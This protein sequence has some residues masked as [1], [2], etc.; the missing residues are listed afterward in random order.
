M[1][2]RYVHALVLAM[3]TAWFPPAVATSAPSESQPQSPPRTP[4][5][6]ESQSI[7]CSPP[8]DLD[9]LFSRG[10]TW[11]SKP[12]GMASTGLL[13][14]PFDRSTL[15]RDLVVSNGND[16]APQPI[17]IYYARKGASSSAFPSYATLPEWVSARHARHGHLAAGDIDRDGLIDLVAAVIVGHP[18]KITVDKGDLYP[19]GGL[20]IYK[21]FDG[22]ADGRAGDDACDRRKTLSPEPIASL[23]GFAAMSVS[24]GD[25]N[26]DGWL[27]LAVGALVESKTP[28]ALPH[29][30][31]KGPWKIFL[32]DHGKFDWNDPITSEKDFNATDVEL[33]DVDLDG[34]LDL[35]MASSR[36]LRVFYGKLGRDGQPTISRTAGWVSDETEFELID[37]DLAPFI[38]S[39]DVAVMNPAVDR[40]SVIV[41]SVSCLQ[42]H[43]AC[44]G[45][46]LLYR[47]DAGGQNRKPIWSY[48]WPGWGGEVRL[49][50]MD[51]D[52]LTDL[53]GGSWFTWNA[54]KQETAPAQIK[55]FLG[56]G[57]TLSARPS[58][59]SEVEGGFVGQAIELVDLSCDAAEL[60]TAHFASP[61][62]AVTLTIPDANFESVHRVRVVI[63]GQEKT[64][65][66]RD[67]TF[68]IGERWV[69]V[70]ALPRGSRIEV[71]YVRSRNPDIVTG[72]FGFNSGVFVF[73][74]F[75][76]SPRASCIT[77]Q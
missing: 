17:T 27:D 28:V 4:I 63:A 52:C 71:D 36:D 12:Q 30:R 2:T 68:A 73:E 25:V 46:Y 64:L 55:I 41:V 38:T 65:D 13:A 42:S 14:V 31:P 69:V 29:E 66:R 51:G 3:S 77:E 8:A 7:E 21:G 6:A 48:A 70:P 15:K 44:S 54:Q 40:E 76:S 67:Y 23:S 75:G 47:P 60:E 72:T 32:N 74:R 58:W 19:M 37:R 16:V 9:H 22:C 49:R 45:R 1:L 56:D 34:R 26:G 50:D 59:E 10:V 18:V 39:V 61:G 53:V 43:Q 11:Q 35:V 57:T 5:L 33:A 24:L 62:H 20:V